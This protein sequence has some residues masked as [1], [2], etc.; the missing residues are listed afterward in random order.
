MVSLRVIERFQRV[1][2]HGCGPVISHTDVEVLA[3]MH[4]DGFDEQRM[5]VSCM[6]EMNRDT[7]GRSIEGDC[8]WS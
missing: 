7:C 2:R 4:T 6:H 3:G 1:A 5:S 8:A